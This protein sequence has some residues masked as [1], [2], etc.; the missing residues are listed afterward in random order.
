MAGVLACCVQVRPAAVPAAV[1]AAVEM[2][3]PLRV[4]WL[5]PRVVFLGVGA[6]ASL[7]CSVFSD[8]VYYQLQCLLGGQQMLCKLC[9]RQVPSR[10][11]DITQRWCFS[12]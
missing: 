8:S 1:G 11:M 5:V 4:L 7:L 6:P 12:R 10:T 9:T 3:E 2:A